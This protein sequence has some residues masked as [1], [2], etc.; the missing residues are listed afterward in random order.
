[1]VAAS[2]VKKNAG[3]HAKKTGRK[4]EPVK[5]QNIKK[6]F[7][8]KPKEPSKAALKK[9]KDAFGFDT[10]SV[11]SEES[12]TVAKRATKRTSASMSAST[13]VKEEEEEE[14]EVAVVESSEP[15]SLADR[16][17]KSKFNTGPLLPTNLPRSRLFC[18]G[19]FRSL[20][21]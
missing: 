2:I 10:D 5:T 4:V 20:G 21:G 3:R 1:M 7:D 12:A 8:K 19:F 16:L 14:D 13:Q 15:L 17:K 11:K 18:I 9:V 6:A